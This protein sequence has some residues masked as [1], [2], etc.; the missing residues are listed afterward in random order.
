MG[1]LTCRLLCFGPGSGSQL[2]VLSRHTSVRCCW[3]L[4]T[5]TAMCKGKSWE[6][7]AEP[8]SFFWK[9]IFPK[10]VNPFPR[11]ESLIWIRIPRLRIFLY[12][13]LQKLGKNS[14]I[15]IPMGFHLSSK[16]FLF[17]VPNSDPRGPT[18]PPSTRGKAGRNNLNEEI[19]PFLPTA[20]G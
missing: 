2:T 19:T 10:Y 3:S 17:E 14:V 20:M 8:L 5:H 18:P 6:K 7:V 9:W 1:T 4:H 15:F 13:F 16:P 12:A 11:S